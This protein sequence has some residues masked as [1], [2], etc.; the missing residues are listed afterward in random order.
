MWSVYPVHSVFADAKEAIRSCGTRVTEGC[1]PVFGCSEL[2]LNSLK[3]EPVLLTGEPSLQCPMN[4]FY[5]VTF[6]L[7]MLQSL[8]PH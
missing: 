2:N 3:Q 6:L 8:C 4:S 7:H 5:V 1:E